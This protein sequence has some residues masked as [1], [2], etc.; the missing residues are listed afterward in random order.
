MHARG[1][2]RGPIAVRGGG[3]HAGSVAVNLYVDKNKTDA[4][5]D[6]EV[7]AAEAML[8]SA[9]SMTYHFRSFNPRKRA[10]TTKH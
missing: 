1:R 9:D 8:D 4:G 3:S 5:V 10:I 6:G 2:R 7:G